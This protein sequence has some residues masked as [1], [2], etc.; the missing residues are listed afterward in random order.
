MSK[1]VKLRLNE[2]RWEDS[3]RVDLPLSLWFSRLEDTPICYTFLAQG[4]AASPLS[5][6]LAEHIANQQLTCSSPHPIPPP[7]KP[8]N[9]SVRDDGKA[10]SKRQEMGVFGLALQCE[11]G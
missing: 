4:I 11:L 1:I 3:F 6:G 5:S 7:P 2:R 8:L 9:A 10:W